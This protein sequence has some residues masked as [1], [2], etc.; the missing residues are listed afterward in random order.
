[1]PQP[2]FQRSEKA[3]A[4]RD[5]IEQ[6]VADIW[7]S[8]LGIPEVGI[9]DNFFE[10][11]GHSL[12]AVRMITEV[13]KAT[14]KQ[15][16]LAVLFQGATIE[17]LANLLRDDTANKEQIVVEIQRGGSK[18][19]LFL[20]VVPGMN[21]LGYAALARHLSHDQ[22]VYKIQGPGPR[23]RGRPYTAAEYGQLAAEYLQ[24]LKTIQP[25]GP[26]YLGGM[27][28]GATIAFDMARLLKANHEGV[29]LLAIF[30]TWVLE[31]TQIR[32]LW[33]IDYYVKRIRGFFRLSR[34]QKRA[35]VAN[36]LRKRISPGK[37]DRESPRTAAPSL[38]WGDVYWPGKN[39]VPPQFAGKIT[40]FKMPEQPYYYVRDPFMGW[41][42][43][44]QDGVELH[45]V[46]IKSN[47][48]ILIF[49]EPH[50][51][52]LAGKLAVCLERAQN[53]N[54]PPVPMPAAEEAV[55]VTAERAES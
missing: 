4:P 38:R 1:L 44:A 31:N 6:Q 8:L 22:P 19:P 53:E 10:L 45:V 12:L 26:Y 7:Q 17:A 28:E 24:A 2:E 43:R 16:P 51:Q 18:P 37:S 47:R 55:M 3:V 30:D 25:E 39:F 21:A 52:L 20:I 11:G 36:L 46:P 27:C 15:I 42:P 13:A 29:A 23:L 40:L 33:T 9:R 14:G 54:S 41:G 49:R 32:S 35:F 48:H 5:E 50:V 34:S